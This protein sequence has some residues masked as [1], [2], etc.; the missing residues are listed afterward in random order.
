M[1]K[2]KINECP[3]TQ[4]KQA[5]VMQQIQLLA[6]WNIANIGKLNTDELPEVRSNV[7]LIISLL[8]CLNEISGNT[9]TEKYSLK[10]QV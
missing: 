6:D 1:E 2:N 10:E 3:D 7:N 8:N 9:L 5:I 4:S